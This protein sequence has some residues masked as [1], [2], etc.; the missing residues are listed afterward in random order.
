[1]PRIRSSIK[2]RLLSPL[3]Q[4]G[5]LV[6]G[7]IRVAL[8][9][10][11]AGEPQKPVRQRVA[12]NVRWAVGRGEV[13]DYYYS[14]G[15]HEPG[16]PPASDFLS[17]KEMMGLIHGQVRDG[18]SQRVVGVLKDKYLFSLVAQA[19]GHRSPRVLAFLDRDGVE[20]LAPRR[21]CPYEALPEEGAGTDGFVK[22]AGGH[23]VELTRFGGQFRSSWRRAPCGGF[24]RG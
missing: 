9:P 7:A 20:W 23:Q 2:S 10:G 4:K 16:A 17:V 22:P 13:N 14:Y 1:M 21:T 18:K 15:L 19:L 5:R 12:E 8:A 24:V 3:A 11:G 6:S